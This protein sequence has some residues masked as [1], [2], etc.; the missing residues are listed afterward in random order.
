MILEDY[1]SLT[2]R[3]LSERRYCD[4]LMGQAWHV[5]AYPV[6]SHEVVVLLYLGAVHVVKSVA[7]CQE[8]LQR[9]GAQVA[10]GEPSTVSLRGGP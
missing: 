4:A 2:A 1:E 5:E 3:P 10:D 6:A 9:C 7:L 8:C